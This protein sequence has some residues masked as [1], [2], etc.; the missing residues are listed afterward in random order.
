MQIPILLGVD[1]ESREILEK[2]QAG[3]FYEPENEQDFFNK[4]EMILQDD[5]EESYKKGGSKL[6]SDFDR[7][8]LAVN[9]LTHLQGVL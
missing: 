4:L 9:M 2:Y 5:H 3:L 7:K 8:K 6:A 1:G